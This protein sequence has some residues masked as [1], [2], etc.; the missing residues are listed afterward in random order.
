MKHLLLALGI[1]VAIGCALFA[2]AYPLVEDVKV[3]GGLAAIPLGSC[4]KITE[5]LERREARMSLSPNYSTAVHSFRG[6]T[7]WWPLTIAYG[8]LIVFAIAE[9]A[10]GLT[11]LLA[12]GLSAVLTG[13]TKM[14]ALASK[15]PIVVGIIAIFVAIPIQM[16]G[17]YMFGRWAGMRSDRNGIVVVLVSAALGAIAMRALDYVLSPESYFQILFGRTKAVEL[18]LWQTVAT[19]ALFALPGLLGYWRGQ[20]L[21]PFKYM[22]YLLGILPHQTRELLVEMAFDEAQKIGTKH[23]SVTAAAHAGDRY[24]ATQPSHAAQKFA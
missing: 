20:K 18:I 7:I 9:F 24:P 13:E 23:A 2:C 6:F 16:V 12:G 4:H 21:R 5:L 22:Q 19:F 14:E 3:A 15:M 11:G 8:A 1:T 17:G 10:S